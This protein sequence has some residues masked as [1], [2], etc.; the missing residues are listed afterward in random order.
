MSQIKLTRVELQ[1]KRESLELA[2]IGKD[3]LEDRLGALISALMLEAR[4]I[5][6]SRQDLVVVSIRGARSLA[7]ASALERDKLVLASFATPVTLGLF[8]EKETI[9]G[10]RIHSFDLVDKESSDEKNPAVSTMTNQ[11][12]LVKTL[13]REQVEI[14]VE[15]ARLEAVVRELGREIKRVRHRFNALN[16][17]LI[18]ELRND[19]N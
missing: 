2:I 11:I 6:R 10:T 1:E 13:F 3:L 9:M 16:D 12:S 18:P 15:L 5:L 4:K 8:R 17:L 14:L 19:I 7:L